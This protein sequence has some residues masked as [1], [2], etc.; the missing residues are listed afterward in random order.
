MVFNVRHTYLLTYLLLKILL[1]E[2]SSKDDEEEKE[3]DDIEDY[4]EDNGWNAYPVKAQ[5]KSN[6][7]SIN[8]QLKFFSALIIVTASQRLNLQKSL[9]RIWTYTQGNSI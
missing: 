8:I 7:D 9:D 3:N 5:L 2:N 6:K 1:V 4:E